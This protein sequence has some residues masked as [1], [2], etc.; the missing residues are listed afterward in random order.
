MEEWRSVP[1]YPEYE[2]SNHGILRRCL[3]SVMS[4]HTYPGRLVKLA[5]DK[6]GY[7]AAYLYSNGERV[8]RRIHHMVAETFLG[9]SPLGN[10]VHHLNGIKTDN[11]LDNLTYVH[12][13]EHYRAAS[14]DYWDKCR[15]GILTHRPRGKGKNNTAK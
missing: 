7:L 14:N 5:I 10:H 8:Y 12:G 6:R 9:P 3:A 2:I 11:R 13:C 1:Y 4:S 15:R